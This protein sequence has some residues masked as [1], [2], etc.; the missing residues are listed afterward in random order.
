MSISA[1]VL[2]ELKK[3]P[4]FD[5]YLELDAAMSNYS[6]IECEKLLARFDTLRDKKMKDLKVITP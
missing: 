1:N 3:D 2:N 6:L 4:K 5:Y